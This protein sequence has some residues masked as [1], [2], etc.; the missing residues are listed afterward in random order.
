MVNPTIYFCFEYGC[1]IKKIKF[2]VNLKI[3]I[4]KIRNRNVSEVE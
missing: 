4:K 1:K 3:N 2:M